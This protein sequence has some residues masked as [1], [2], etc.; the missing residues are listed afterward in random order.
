MTERMYRLA[1]LSAIDLPAGLTVPLKTM[2]FVLQQGR[3]YG[4]DLGVI[5]SDAAGKNRAARLYWANKATGLTADVPGEAM[6]T[7]NLWRKGRPEWARRRKNRPSA[8]HGW[9]SGAQKWPPDVHGGAPRGVGGAFRLHGRVPGAHAGGPDGAQRT[10]ADAQR[11][12]AD[13][14]PCTCD[15]RKRP[16]EVPPRARETPPRGLQLDFGA[17][18]GYIERIPCDPN[19]GR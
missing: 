19:R 5:F 8:G 12:R 6:A 9:P 2:G 4:I 14:R 3:D 13:A 7:P 15:A 18:L 1:P 11:T 10:R 17:R 16:S